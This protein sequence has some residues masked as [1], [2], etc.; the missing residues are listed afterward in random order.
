MVTSAD[1][2]YLGFFQWAVDPYVGDLRYGAIFNHLLSLCEEIYD[3]D[4]DDD[5]GGFY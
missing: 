1:L 3:D 2:L 5:D 4:E